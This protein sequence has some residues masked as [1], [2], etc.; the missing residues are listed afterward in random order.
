[1]R[2]FASGLFC[3][4]ILATQ[5]WAAVITVTATLSGANEVPPNA[6]PATGFVFASL[7]N[8]AH[9]LFVDLSF[10][11]LIGGT[12][13]AAHIH[14][15]AP[16]GTTVGVAV[17][18]TGFPAST[19]GT[20][21]HT[22]DTSDS[23]IYLAGFLAANGGTAAGAEAGLFAGMQTFMTY[24]NIHDSVFPGGEIRGQLVPEPMTCTL[25]AVG[26]LVLA[27]IRRRRA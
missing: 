25:G 7:D 16:D 24:A 10:S 6:S 22:F 5:G 2:L 9:T 8:V 19:S 17:P 13:S 1:M 4:G 23:S 27:C 18:F 20:Y 21:T 3:A 26:L 12:A 11:G 14:C 15:C